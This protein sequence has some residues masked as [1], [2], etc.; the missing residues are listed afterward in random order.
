M[1]PLYGKAVELP[2]RCPS[3]YELLTLVDALR[4]GRARERKI[5]AEHLRERLAHAGALQHG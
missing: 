4:V 1:D 5:A 2:E 3:V